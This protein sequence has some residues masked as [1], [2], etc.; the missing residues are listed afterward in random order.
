ME[1]PLNEIRIDL[2]GNPKLLEHSKRLPDGANTSVEIKFRK[3][4]VTGDGVLVG[5]MHSISPE[6]YSDTSAEGEEA[7][8]EEPSADE[9]VMVMISRQKDK[10]LKPQ[11]EMA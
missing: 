7:T 4:S 5:V 9:P 3:T 6:G 10:E 8:E 2:R 1:T 11:P